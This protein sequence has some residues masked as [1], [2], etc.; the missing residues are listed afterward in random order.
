VV[1]STFFRFADRDMFMRFRGGG[2]GHI[3][4]L[5]HTRVFETDAGVDEQIL[6]VY[7]EDG[8]VID[9]EVGSDE[10]DGEEEVEEEALNEFRLTAANYDSDASNDS[11]GSESSEHE[12]LEQGGDLGPEDGELEDTEAF[13][14]E[15][16][17][18]GDY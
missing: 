2:P 12:G 6:P 9:Q 15:S 16:L 14:Y 5:E 13:G 10:E 18:Y 3:S 4:T 17:G 8:N 11:D 1:Y 7:D